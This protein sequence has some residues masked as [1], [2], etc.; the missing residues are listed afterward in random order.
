VGDD[1]CLLVNIFLTDKG[2]LLQLED[3]KAETE[4]LLLL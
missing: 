2:L 4:R 3:N 1:A